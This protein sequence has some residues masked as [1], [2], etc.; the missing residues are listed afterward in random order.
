MHASARAQAAQA[1]TEPEFARKLAFGPERVDSAPPPCSTLDVRK[2]SSIRLGLLLTVS[3]LLASCG[4]EKPRERR[5]VDAD[6]RFSDEGL[7]STG[8]PGPTGGQG[9]ASTGSWDAPDGNSPPASRGGYHF[10][11][12][13]YGLYG[14]V[15]TY[16]PGFMSPGRSVP[17]TPGPATP[18]SV[19]RGGFGATGAAHAGAAPSTS[20]GSA[21]T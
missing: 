14:G 16:A 4:G 5:C 21:G 8:S 3:A 9:S 17:G 13:P 7:C 11:W 2:S 20:P 10:I 18:G 12:I 1:A 6:G 19:S 15:G